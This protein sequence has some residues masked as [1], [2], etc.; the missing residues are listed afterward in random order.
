M[1]HCLG[2]S[3][4]VWTML[5]V[6]ESAAFVHPGLLSTQED[7]ERM[8]F[9]VAAGEQPWKGSW[10]ILVSNT[11]SFLHTEPEVRPIINAGGGYSEDYIRLARD[12][13]RAY[14]C[15]LRYQISGE[16]AYANKAVQILNTWASTMTGWSGDTNVSLR[17]GLYGYQMACAAELMRDYP[18]W[19][20]A[21]F[22]A[23]QNWML[24]VFYTKNSS[25][26]AHH[27]G[28]CDSH[29]WAN[30]DLANMASGMAIG[31]LCDR[32]DIFEKMLDYFYNGLGNGSIRNA[33]YFIH[34]DGTGQWQES[35]RDQGHTTLGVMLMGVICEMAWNQGIDLY[36]YDGNR[37]LAG[38]EYVAKYNLGYE[39]PFVTYM[40]CEYPNW[41]AHSAVSPTARGQ[42]RP[43]WEMIFN[44][45]VNRKGFSAPYT[46]QFAEK[47]RPE[48]GG[49]NYGTTSGGFDQLGFTT[50]TH[51]REPIASGAVPS[52]PRLTVQ[53]R[54]IV[55]AWT[56]S[57]YAQSCNVKRGTLRNGPYMTIAQTKE[58]HYTDTGL[59]PGITYSYAVSANTP[60]GE[61]EDSA[62]AAATA[63]KQLF[64]TVIGTEG[65]YKNAGAVK[66]AV[67]DGCLQNFFDAPSGSAWAGLD[68]GEGVRAR[69][70]EIRYCPRPGY[71][72]RMV[73][74]RFQGSNTADFSG[75]V[76]D[77]FTISAQPSDE[78]LT[79]QAISNPNWF[80][81][82]RYL[83]P[84]DGYGNA[85]EVQ[86]FGD[87]AGQGVP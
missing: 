64:G 30:W 37:F 60:E 31:V 8:R 76:V 72:R 6:E 29:Y 25:F 43:G 77:L 84:A 52:A 70:T 1:M 50:L 46:R 28:T 44:H 59:T 14:Q 11:N 23:F 42:M 74:G 18:G 87:L 49:F 68:F 55:L 54:Q 56:G 53:G 35:G 12:C 63:D 51:T 62:P 15:A 39:V 41:A 17:A 40:T 27:H 79:S 38:C 80:R 22:A 82:V 5:G 66:D 75:E 19:V 67:F 48:G 34:P 2:L 33:V 65:S 86:F 7:L 26:L 78:V 81:Y 3:I 36:G 47:V 73:G 57:A 69:I 4:F 10:D 83:S 21:D 16:T 20:P 45:Y 9:K 61:T 32:Q 13:A 85:A 58:T 71:G 24:D